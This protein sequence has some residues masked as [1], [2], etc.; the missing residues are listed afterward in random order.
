MDKKSARE[1][2]EEIHRKARGAQD[3][4]GGRV[5]WGGEGGGGSDGGGRGK[6]REEHGT[7]FTEPRES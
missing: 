6:E 1:R 2:R 4:P 7:G 3:E 5:E